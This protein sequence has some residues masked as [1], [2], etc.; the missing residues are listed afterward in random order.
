MKFTVNFYSEEFEIDSTNDFNMFF[1][2]VSSKLNIEINSLEDLVFYY[3]KNDNHKIIIKDCESFNSAF[4]YFINRKNLK[5]PYRIPVIY[6]TLASKNINNSIDNKNL[7]SHLS[8][9]SIDFNN[10]D[11]NKVDYLININKS[12]ENKINNLYADIKELDE[13]LQ[14]NNNNCIQSINIEENIDRINSGTSKMK[15]ER[16]NHSYEININK[17][18]NEKLDFSKEIILLENSIKEKNETVQF[19]LLENSIT[20]DQTNK[21]SDPNKHLETNEESTITNLKNNK[22]ENI[23]DQERLTTENLM[24]HSN[25]EFYEG[26]KYISRLTEEEKEIRRNL[27]EKTLNTEKPEEN[28]EKLLEAM[29][30]IQPNKLFLSYIQ[31]RTNNNHGSKRDQVYLEYIESDKVETSDDRDSENQE[32]SNEI[33]IAELSKEIQNILDKKFKSC[34]KKILLLAENLFKDNISKQ[35]KLTKE[36]DFL[37][38]K[39]ALKKTVHHGVTCDGC[40]QSPI[41]GIRYKCTVCDDFDYCD[42]CENKLSEDHKHP[43]LKIKNPNQS[44][45]LVKC[46]LDNSRQNNQHNNS[47]VTDQ[48]PEP[49][50]NNDIFNRDLGKNNSNIIDNLENE[51]KINIVIKDEPIK[52]EEKECENKPNIE[53]GTSNQPIKSSIFN[54]VKN[55]F[56]KI[57][58][59]LL[60]LFKKNDNSPRINTISKNPKS[61]KQN[62]EEIINKLKEEYYIPNV[63][64]ELLIQSLEKA[65]GDESQAIDYLIELMNN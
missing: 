6:I 31:N 2:L 22:I 9:K 63:S 38:V 33:I 17:L 59:K 18:E 65:N 55:A 56:N 52:E 21:I 46:V 13:F 58:D 62:Y 32:N 47:L 20:S 7:E 8:L 41:L 23:L 19:N 48:I 24:L 15:I 45:Y 57:P 61:K 39:K 51:N 64:D 11:Q 36:T 40:N 35:A 60:N 10:C 28:K 25:G 4:K 34:K 44:N 30:G 42:D 27:V 29:E 43:F 14:L 49:I 26:Q 54:D 37:N 12:D 53:E 3:Q 1:A 5:G 16:E 50:L